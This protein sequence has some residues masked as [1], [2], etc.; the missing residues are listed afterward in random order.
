MD[1]KKFLEIGIE[2]SDEAFEAFGDGQFL[3]AAELF[4]RSIEEYRKCELRIKVVI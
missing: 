1:A 4:K 3:K 2:V